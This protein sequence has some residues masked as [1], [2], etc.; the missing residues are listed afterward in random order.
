MGRRIEFTRD[1][2]SEVMRLLGNGESYRNVAR[3]MGMSLGMVQRISR[4][5]SFRRSGGYLMEDE[6]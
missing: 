4:L 2:V 3:L 6:E 5:N 1:E